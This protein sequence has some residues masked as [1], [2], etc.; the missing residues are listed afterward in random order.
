M[1]SY[2]VHLLDDQRLTDIVMTIGIWHPS[3]EV[4][5]FCYVSKQRYKFSVVAG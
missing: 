4:E 5:G 2:K 3:E 1:V